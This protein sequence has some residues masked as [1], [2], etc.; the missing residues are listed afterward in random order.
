MIP[1]PSLLARDEMG[2]VRVDVLG[3]RPACMLDP[4]LDLV[5]LVAEV[6]CRGESDG[7]ECFAHDDSDPT[8]RSVVS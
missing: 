4:V 1:L 6:A 8:V 5:S 7:T 2:D 3:E